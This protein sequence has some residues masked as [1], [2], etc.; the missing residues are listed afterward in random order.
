MYATVIKA[1]CL[2]RSAFTM[3]ELVFV[4]VVIGII[5]SMMLPRIDRDNL[6]EAAQ[7]VVS[8]IK[9]TQHLALIDNV[10]NDQ[11]ATW[12]KNRWQI[13][14][15]KTKGTDNEWSY[16][17]FSDRKNKDGNPNES[18]IAVDP[19]DKTKRLT[20][21][22]SGLIKY[23]DEKASENL[24]LGHS[25]NI[26]DIDFYDCGIKNSN[27]KKR[28]FFDNL[29][30]PFTDNPEYLIDP[31]NQKRKTLLLRSQC[32]IEL[33]IV[34]DCKVAN[35]DEKI[36]IAVEAETGYTHII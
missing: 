27:G 13:K 30:R 23:A 34:S 7:Q 29:G 22:Y 10:Y 15:S 20:G 6:Y 25:Y 32:K 36:T 26:K 16:A 9:Y 21:G 3:I 19:L 17:I 4:F 35:E 18:E 12:Y 5:T 1:H 2:K 28:I 8:H 14:F 33:C 11:D 31:F 24:N